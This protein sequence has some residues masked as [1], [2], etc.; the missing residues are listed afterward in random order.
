MGSTQLDKEIADLA[1][2]GKIKLSE[3]EQQ[4]ICNEMVSSLNEEE[5]EIAARS[6]YKYMMKAISESE[7]KS[8][9]STNE[10]F[11]TACKMARRH[12]VASKGDKESGLTQMK[13]TIAFRK[14]KCV[15]DLRRCYNKD[16]KNYNTS[17][18]VALRSTLDKAMETSFLSVIGYSKKREPIFIQLPSV[19]SD[20]SNYEGYLQANIFMMEKAN[21]CSERFTNGEKEKFLIF[22]DYN[23]FGRKNFPPLKLAKDI[24]DVLREHYP[25]RLENVYLIDT[26]MIFRGFYAIIKHFI[27]PITVR[28]VRFVTGL[29]QRRK[30]FA[31]VAENSEIMPF[32]LPEGEVSQPIDIKKLLHDIPFDRANNEGED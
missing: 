23:H 25:E 2:Q 30:E 17:K 16:D 24:S 26:P 5:Q 4:K 9:S 10:R 1:V 27:D 15:D 32:I 22:L 11:S 8:K 28:K 29:Q 6:S 12:L 31:D 7:S 21:A 14:E 19:I 20:F 18:Y 13:K 3:D